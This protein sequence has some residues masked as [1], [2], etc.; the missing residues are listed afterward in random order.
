M[1]SARKVKAITISVT[2]AETQYGIFLVN[3]CE[4]N[5]RHKTLLVFDDQV[6]KESYINHVVLQSLDHSLWVMSL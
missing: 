4:H 2:L 3:E 1:K 6:I 5:G